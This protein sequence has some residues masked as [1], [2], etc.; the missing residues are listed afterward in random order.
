[1]LEMMHGN[2]LTHDGQLGADECFTFVEGHSVDI[3]SH[4]S[5]QQEDSVHES[6]AAAGDSAMVLTVIDEE[7]SED[8][9]HQ[10]Y[11]PYHYYHPEPSRPNPRQDKLFGVLTSH[12]TDKKD[13]VR[14]APASLVQ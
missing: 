10:P 12:W 7:E 2:D 13:Q 9:L 3:Y 4:T 6:A 8:E 5:L 1:M 14:S 11:Q